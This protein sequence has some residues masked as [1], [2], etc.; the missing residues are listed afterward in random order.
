MDQMTATIQARIEAVRREKAEAIVNRAN[1]N[2]QRLTKHFT[3]DVEINSGISADGST[4]FSE[5]IS[6]WLGVQN[7][8]AT[9]PARVPRKARVLRFT[10]G[11]RGTLVRNSLDSVPPIR[12][13]NVVFTKKSRAFVLP[14]GNW[15]K[16]NKKDILEKLPDL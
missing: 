16:A 13:T 9:I 3:A 6:P 8:G 12:G 10:T 4:G 15:G 7:R 1:E 5:V 11:G 2:W 14:P